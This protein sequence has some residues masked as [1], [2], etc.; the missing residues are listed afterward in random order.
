[1][2]WLIL[3]PFWV[4]SIAEYLAKTHCSANMFDLQTIFIRPIW[5]TSN[6]PNAQIQESLSIKVEHSANELVGTTGS[7]N[8]THIICSSCCLQNCRPVIVYSENSQIHGVNNFWYC[9]IDDLQ[10]LH[11]GSYAV[12]LVANKDWDVL[13]LCSATRS[14]PVHLVPCKP[15]KRKL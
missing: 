7:P 5:F 2:W 1:M 3:F 13:C 4:T 6:L 9:S 15:S 8:L 14:K 12:W 10:V 11:A